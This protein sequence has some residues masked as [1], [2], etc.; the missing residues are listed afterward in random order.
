MSTID[1]SGTYTALVTP[2]RDD[3]EQSIDWEAFDELIDGQIEAG[4]TGLVPCGTTGESPTLSHHEHEQV[5]VRTV[6]RARGRAQVIAGIGSNSTR[7]AIELAR[8]AERAGASVVMGVVPYYNKPTQEGLRRHFLAIARAVSLPVMIYNIPAR[9][10]IDLSADTLVRIVEEAPNVVATKEATGHVLRTQELSRRLGSRLSILSGDDALTL[11]LIA[12]GARGI[13][14]VT[15]NL[16]P[17][18]VVRATN[19][20]LSGELAQA[21]AAHLA[22]LPVHESMFIEAN[23]GPVKAALAARG[24]MKNV[25]RSPLVPVSDATRASVIATVDAY[26]LKHG[27]QS[28]SSAAS[29]G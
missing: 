23:P 6:Q 25:V 18:E 20:A 19:L 7:E 24:K 22:L 21:R 17:R 2:F 29:A 14:S 26:L 10:G 8:A 3:E 27:A 15:S 28:Q 5:I 4:I 9:T 16:L 12:V 13:I 1:L 11:P